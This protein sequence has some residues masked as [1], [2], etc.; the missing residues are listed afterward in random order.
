[1]E[2]FKG[3]S[4]H[5]PLHGDEIRLL[6]LLPGS[7]N[8]PIICYLEHDS[9][10]SAPRYDDLS[11]VWGDA[12]QTSLIMLDG[13]AFL[14]CGL[15]P[16]ASINSTFQERNVQVARMRD[17]FEQANRTVIWL[18]DYAPQ[19][20]ESVDSAFNLVER[21][22]D[23]LK[24][25][26]Y[27]HAAVQDIIK[28]HDADVRVLQEIVQRPWFYGVWAI[29]EIAMCKTP[30]EYNSIHNI[31]SI[32]RRYRN[33]KK[34]TTSYGFTG[35]GA[36]QLVTFLSRGACAFEAT[37]ERDKICALL[38]LLPSKI[39]PPQLRPNYALTAEQ[40]F[41]DYAVYMLEETKYLDIPTC[42]SGSRPGLPSWVLDWK[43]GYSSEPFH[44]GKVSYIRFLEGNKKMEID[45]M[46]LSH[47]AKVLNPVE[48]AA[49]FT[50]RVELEWESEDS[51][52]TL[53]QSHE[54]IA[55]PAEAMSNVYGI[56]P[57]VE[58]K[59]FGCRALDAN[60]TP[61]ELDRWDCRA[62][63]WVRGI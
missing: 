39:L 13:N 48:I 9:L 34:Q 42:C 5:R 56:L 18:G 44:L 1:M 32:Y 23:I 6:K 58:T 22:F 37:D 27:T 52:V 26:G 12:T 14:L 46:V 24:N 47:I 10:A 43:N 50:G 38:G 63:D 59:W 40:I 41:G 54:K 35:C 17:I 4:R 25:G 60:L 19:T 15:M 7:F 53:P 57:S 21:V 49:E 20:K 28:D 51:A 29:Q 62:G 2:L 11:Y 3:P 16:F 36:E 45:C 33:G 8:D 55:N 61:V 31:L 30:E